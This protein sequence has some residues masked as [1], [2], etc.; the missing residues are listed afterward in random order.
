[1]NDLQIKKKEILRE[2]KKLS[3]LDVY[4]LRIKTIK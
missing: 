4:Y 3:M 2:K 1:M